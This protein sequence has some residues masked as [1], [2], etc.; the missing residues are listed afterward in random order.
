[1]FV[2]LPCMRRDPFLDDILKPKPLFIKYT[3]YNCRTK[4]NV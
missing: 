4:S 3:I 1:M 2:Y